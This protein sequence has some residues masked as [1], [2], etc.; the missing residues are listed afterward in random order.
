MKT[1]AEIVS[2]IG[3]FPH[4]PHLQSSQLGT[5]GYNVSTVQFP[6]CALY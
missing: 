1:A 4:L 2:I 3:H 5:K 6:R